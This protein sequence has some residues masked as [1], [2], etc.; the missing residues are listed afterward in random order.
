MSKEAFKPFL[1]TDPAFRKMIGELVLQK[2]ATARRRA[3]MQA[4][5]SSS[6]V[7]APEAARNEVK[8]STLKKVSIG[9]LGGACVR[10][11]SRPPPSMNT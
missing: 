6:G 3:D 4:L 5:A 11:T 1:E 9:T 8:L 10:R 7:V 2:E